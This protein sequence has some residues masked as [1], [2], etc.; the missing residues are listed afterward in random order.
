[1]TQNVIL[2]ATKKAE[3]LASGNQAGRAGLCSQDMNLSPAS[4][5]E[6]LSH[7]PRDSRRLLTWVTTITTGYQ[8]FMDK[9]QKLLNCIN[10]GSG[11]I[12]TMVQGQLG[13]K[14]RSKLFSKVALGFLALDLRTRTWSYSL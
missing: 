1:M 4:V 14:R 2:L 7:I 11:A 12:R 10:R 9:E 3:G 13:D 5:D 8:G 6:V